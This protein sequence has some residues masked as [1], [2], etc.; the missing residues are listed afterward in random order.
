MATDD[1]TRVNEDYFVS[2][3]KRIGVS[4]GTAPFFALKLSEKGM[5]Y[6]G[7]KHDGAISE[8]YFIGKDLSRAEDELEFYERAITVAKGGDDDDDG[9]LSKLLE[10]TF[11]YAGIVTLP[12]MVDD[13]PVSRQLIVLRNLFDSKQKLRLLDFKIGEKTAAANW[14]GKSRLRAFK[15]SFVDGMTN[16]TREGFRLEGFDGKPEVIT[17]MDP[18]LDLKL[19]KSKEST[20]T[21]AQKAMRM[22]LQK[23]SGGQVLMYYLDLHEVPSNKSQIQFKCTKEDGYETDPY[24]DSEVTEIVLRQTLCELVKLYATCRSTTVPQKWLGSSVALGYDGNYFPSRSDENEEKIREGVIVNIFDWGRSELL[25]KIAY[26]KLSIDEK[27]DRALYWGY[28]VNGLK[29]LSYNAAD[30]YYDQFSNSHDW[31]EVTVRVLD[32]DSNS[33]DDFIGEVTIPLLNQ[34]TRYSE[35]FVLRN[36]G[37]SMLRDGS[38]GGKRGSIKIDISWW[39][40]PKTCSH[41]R[42]S[43]RV[44]IDSASKLKAMDITTSDPYCL[45]IAKSSSYE[46]EQMTSVKIQTLNPVWEETFELPVVSSSSKLLES[47]RAQGLDVD[48]QKLTQLF[49][50]EIKGD[51]REAWGDLFK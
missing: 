24:T 23:M 4:G 2:P 20:S 14:R 16:S 12:E 3:V 27:K 6:F 9:G 50:T 44:K 47:L 48:P 30:R 15:Q 26:D 1:F 29:H 37:K 33:A 39:E 28:Y 35:E 46:F 5:E 49:G 43:W 19:K 11:E 25:T 10:F 13:S 45:I 40:A 31:K 32:Y 17:S 36:M 41:L 42:G 22:A 34:T 21:T 38:A 7:S 51:P 18:L 8:G